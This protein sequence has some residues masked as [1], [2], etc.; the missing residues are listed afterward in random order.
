M[1]GWVDASSGASGDMLLG[2]LFGA[3]VPVEVVGRAVLAAAAAA[4]A[5]PGDVSVTAGTATRHGF[6]ATRA[7]VRVADSATHRTW[8]DI[9]EALRVASLDDAVRARAHDAPSSGWPSPRPPCTAPR[10]RT[11]TSTRSA[12]STRSPTWS[13]SAPGSSTSVS[14]RSSSRPSRSAPV[15]CAAR[16]ATMPVPPPAVAELLRGVPSYAGPGRP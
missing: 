16:T 13:G 7:D 10:P 9:R 8:R 6:A 1:I 12:P 5:E 14:T 15:A 11:C 2:A 4:G 3:G